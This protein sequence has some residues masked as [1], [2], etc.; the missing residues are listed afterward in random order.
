MPFSGHPT[1]WSP[2]NFFLGTARR[3]VCLEVGVVVRVY[4]E[5]VVVG[6]IRC[7]GDQ[8]AV[9]LKDG[10]GGVAGIDT[11]KGDLEAYV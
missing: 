7:Q 8:V 3:V 10:A 9:V 4:H 2:P 11:I 6:R 5:L 1:L